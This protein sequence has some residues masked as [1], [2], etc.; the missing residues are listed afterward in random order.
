[1]AMDGCLL[2]PRVQSRTRRN[3]PQ[4]TSHSAQCPSF[5]ICK[6]CNAERARNIGTMVCSSLCGLGY[7]LATQ[8]AGTRQGPFGRFRSSQAAAVLAIAGVPEI[9]DGPS[10]CIVAGVVGAKRLSETAGRLLYQT[11]LLEEPL[12]LFPQLPCNLLTTWNGSCPVLRRRASRG[13]YV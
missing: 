5:R 1:M 7:R 4:Q 9:S 6:P 11:L 2:E 12:K 13:G 8:G 3:V 10:G